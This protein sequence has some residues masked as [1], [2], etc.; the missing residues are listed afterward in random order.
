MTEDTDALAGGMADTAPAADAAPG[1]ET[2]APASTE[3]AN[4]GSQGTIADGNV[5]EK[6][7]AAPADWPE[8]W[9]IKLAGEDKSYLKTL[10]R[11]NTPADLAKA[12]RD[13]QARL[14]AGNLK[15]VLPENPT[16]EELKTWRA[17]NGVPDSPDKYDVQLGNGF[18]WSD[19]DKPLLDDFAQY[20]HKANMPE[21]QVKQVLGWYA[22]MQERQQAAMEEAD[23]R[24]HQE[25]EDK[26][27]SEWGQEFRRNTNA[28]ANLL[29]VHATP[30]VKA[31][32]L[33]SRLPNGRRLGDDP[34]ALKVL[35]SMAREANPEYTVVPAPGFQNF[36]G[37]LEA[38]QKKV[39]T[40]EYWR[41]P[42]MQARYRELLE[43]KSARE[44]KG[45]AA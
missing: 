11:F 33:L 45:R 40:Q 2:T 32:I 31:D 39:G 18:V 19:A 7:V 12:Y 9:R 14:S 36:E 27:R 5:T 3:T 29:D 4:T 21:G 8:D 16:E 24:F 28:I 30:E 25:S 26:L 35:A 34:A 41:D 1:G 22:A 37:E 6:P 10:D 44:G 23:D 15:P 13:A 42:K 17:E 43:A 38:L 20:A